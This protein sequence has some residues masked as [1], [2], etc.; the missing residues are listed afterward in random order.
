MGFQQSEGTELGAFRRRTERQTLAAV[1]RPTETQPLAACAPGTRRQ[2]LH[3]HQGHA[4]SCAWWCL[5]T[6]TL[7]EHPMAC[8]P[9]LPAPRGVAPARPRSSMDSMSSSA[10]G[11]DAHAGVTPFPTTPTSAS[12][13]APAPRLP[14]PSPTR[15]DLVRYPASPRHPLVPEPLEESL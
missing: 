7:W 10:P 6:A 13:A 3:Q 11:V 9:W 15:T 4:F 2:L 14:P 12:K 8:L 1:R 5:A